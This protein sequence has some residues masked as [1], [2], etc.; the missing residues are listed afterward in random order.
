MKIEN[1]AKKA[2]TQLSYYCSDQKYSFYQK[3]WF[4]LK[5]FDI[6]KIKGVLVL[7][8]KCIET[9]YARVFTYQFSSFQHNPN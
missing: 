7:K 9:N 6:S 3:S 2:L 5:M 1:R 8:G 4:F